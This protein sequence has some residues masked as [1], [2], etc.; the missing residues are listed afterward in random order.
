MLQVNFLPWRERRQKR[1]LQHFVWL[2]ILYLVL[3]LLGLWG[4]YFSLA[5]Q[6][7]RLSEQL[8]TIRDANDAIQ[9]EI[10]HIQQLQAQVA[11]RDQ[12]QRDIARIRQAGKNIQALFPNLER[13]LSPSLWLKL[14]T[15]QQGRLVIE[16]Q[17]RGYQTIVDFY[18]KMAI[19]PLISEL[20][21][22]NVSAIGVELYAFRLSAD[23][24]E[25]K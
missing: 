9:Q 7:Q 18:Q 10:R 14:I 4:T 13:S 3:I 23:W 15:I 8:V 12:S 19:S 21:L 20:L 5:R 11:I 6:N 25:A 17:G 1:A 24:V 22:A 2:V 16:G